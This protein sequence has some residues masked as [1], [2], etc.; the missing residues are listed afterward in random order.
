M[1]KTIKEQLN[2][3]PVRSKSVAH[4]I[5]RLIPD[6]CP[7]NRTLKIGEKTLVTI[8]PLC[9]LNPVYEELMGL[10]FRALCYLEKSS[11]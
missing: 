5:C 11:T 2:R 1:V 3:I 4:V 7:F 8:P 10:R 9:K 6:Q